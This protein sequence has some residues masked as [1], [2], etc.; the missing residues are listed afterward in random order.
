M[1]DAG[2]RRWLDPRRFLD[3]L[4]DPFYATLVDL[5]HQLSYST[6]AHWHSK[7]LR[8]I[9]LPFTTTSV[10][11]PMGRGSDSSPVHVDVFGVPTYLADSMQFV[12]EYGCRLNPRGAFYLMPSFRGEAA[13]ATHLCQF[14]H[15][16]A[17]TAGGLD[18]ALRAAE[19]YVR[20]VTGSLLE[21]CS[22]AI[23]SIAGT[24]GH[25]ERVVE[26]REFPRLSFDEAADILRDTPDG[27]VHTSDWRNLTRRGERALM[28]HVGGPV[29]V[30]HWDH[31][32]VPFYQAYD[33]TGRYARN[34]D[35][36]LGLGEMIGSGERHM[37]GDDV[38]AALK[39]HEVSE[40]DYAW[41]VE[42]KQSRPMRTAGFGMGVERY[43]AWVL[44]HD[45]VRDLQILCRFNGY[46]TAP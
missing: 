24:V 14:F 31:L 21:A 23:A 28:A 5:Q 26:A 46:A 25:L 29:W 7:G 8:N 33:E 35:F 16:E 12:L 40:A 18:D 39:H 11:S 19:E 20:A 44:D 45:D 6:M 4:D 15:S 42:L 22:D 37:T 41:Y 2:L 30:T 1:S 9:H 38:R 10:S 32:A 3:I 27:I 13:S 17:E 34:A 43:L 36:L